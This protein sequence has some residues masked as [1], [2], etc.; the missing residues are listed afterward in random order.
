MA[1]LLEDFRIGQRIALAV[2]I[3]LSIV[4]CIAVS[5]YFVEAQL[6][7]PQLYEGIPLDSTLLR[8]DKQALDESYHQYILLLFSVWLKG[9]IS[10]DQRIRAGLK[11]ARAAYNSAARQIAQ[12]EQELLKEDRV[13]QNRWP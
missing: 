6:L 1:P 2:V 9:D 13:K 12:R 8:L 5:D 10:E 7:E 11:K 3:V 4:F